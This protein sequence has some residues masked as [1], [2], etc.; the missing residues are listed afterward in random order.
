M[1]YKQL[2]RELLEQKKMNDYFCDEIDKQKD[3][4]VKYEYKNEES[5]RLLQKLNENITKREEKLQRELS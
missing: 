2:E 1:K 4:V 5:L 3:E